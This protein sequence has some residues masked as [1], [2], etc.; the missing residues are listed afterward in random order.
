MTITATGRLSPDT[1]TVPAFPLSMFDAVHRGAEEYDEQIHVNLAERNSWRARCRGPDRRERSKSVQRKSDAGRW[2][3][4]H[5]S[6]MAQGDWTD[7]AHERITFG[8]YALAWLDS[9]G[10]FAS[11]PRGRDQVNRGCSRWLRPASAV[12]PGRRRICRNRWAESGGA[13][14]PEAWP[15]VFVGAPC[16]AR[17]V[18][19]LSR[20]HERS[21]RSPASNTATKTPTKGTA[22]KPA[23]GLPP[24][25]A[26][27]AVKAMLTPAP[28]A[29][30]R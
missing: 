18:E 12:C 6:L 19:P 9:R 3:I 13:R 10:W 22:M 28:T 4:Q 25:T 20:T 30:P 23:I 26:N 2:L 1:G 21:V 11:G 5:R 16:E 7:P 8:E 17:L 24:I 15:S 29:V 14:R 27:V